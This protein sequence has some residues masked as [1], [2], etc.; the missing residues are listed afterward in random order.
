MLSVP[1]MR[2]GR[3]DLLSFDWRS[4]SWRPNTLESQLVSSAGI[5]AV[6]SELTVVVGGEYHIT[7]ALIDFCQLGTE[8]H[9]RSTP[10]ASAQASARCWS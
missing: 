2:D 10:T 9:Y 1:Q 6:A 7:N 8:W 4:S 3:L 5:E